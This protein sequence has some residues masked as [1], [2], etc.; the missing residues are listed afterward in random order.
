LA[1]KIIFTAGVRF[2]PR[3]IDT[4]LIRKAISTAISDMKV[5]LA[6]KQVTVQRSAIN[7]ISQQL[8]QKI[9]VH[10][11]A[12]NFTFNGGAVAAR[13]GKIIRDAGKELKLKV[14]F[15]KAHLIA[16]VKQTLESMGVTVPAKV[17]LQDPTKSVQRQ[18]A[19]PGKQL[20]ADQEVQNMANLVRVQ[21]D[22]QSSMPP[23]LRAQ[24]Q[25]A[26]LLKNSGVNA[27]WFG[28]KIAQVTAR[29]AAYAVAIRGIFA[30]QQAF[31]NS[32]D[33]IIKFDNVISDLQKVL[34]T[35]PEVLKNTADSMFQVAEATGRSFEDVATAMNTFIRQDLGVTKALEMTQAALMATNISELTAA[36][37]TKFLT[38]VTRVYGQ[39]AG[40]TTRIL[41]VLSV[42]ADNAATTAAGL[43]QA[44]IRSGAAAKAVGVT[45]GEL[46]AVTAAVIETTQSS[47]EKVGTALKTIF[48]RL[49][50]TNDKIRA[51]AN[52]WGANIQATDGV[53]TTLEK[54]SG[55]YG[56]L[57]MFQR[58]QL[59]YLVAGRRRFTEFSA[60]L[61]GFGKTN[62]LLAKQENAA[63]TAAAK[64]EVELSKLS[65]RVQQIRNIWNEFIQELAGTKGGAEGVGLLRG[66]LEDV[67]SITKE[68]SSGLKGI[69]V[70]IKEMG[71]S[72]LQVSTVF[73]AIAKTAFFTIGL[74][75]IR[76][77][78]A[79][80]RQFLQIGQ[81]IQGLLIGVS[82]KEKEILGMILQQ[83]QAAEG[84]AT[85]DQRRLAIKE[86]MA[87]AESR[88][89]TASMRT[90]LAEKRA[91]AERGKV[92][93]AARGAAKSGAGKIA[94]FGAFFL[95]TQLLADGMKNFAEEIG[96]IAAKTGAVSQEFAAGVSRLGGKAVEL[97]AIVTAVTGNLKSGLIA[98]I[99][100]AGIQLALFA[101]ELES[102]KWTVLE[103]ISSQSSMSLSVLDVVRQNN[104]L[105]QA[106][107][108]LTGNVG[109]LRDVFAAV[110]LVRAVLEA[111]TIAS[112]QFNDRLS[113]LAIATEQ[114]TSQLTA[115]SRAFDLQRALRQATQNIQKQV[116]QIQVGL[117]AGDFGSEFAP[118]IDAISEYEARLQNIDSVHNGVYNKIEATKRALEAWS[119][120]QDPA[121]GDS[122]RILDSYQLLSTEVS[123]LI[124]SQREAMMIAEQEVDANDAIISMREEEIS[125]IKKSIDITRKNL[126]AIQNI[127]SATSERKALQNDLNILENASA[128][129]NKQIVELNSKNEILLGRINDANEEISNVMKQE[130]ESVR[131][132]VVAYKSQ[133]ASVD[134]SL[135]KEI[136]RLAKTELETVELQK[137]V[138]IYENLR[139]KGSDF[140]NSVT[141][142]LSAAVA[143]LNNEIDK[144]TQQY[145]TNI[146]K[147]QQ[148][149]DAAAAAGD[150]QQANTLEDKR[151]ALEAVQKELIKALKDKGIVELQAKFQK[152]QDEEV[153]AQSKALADYRISQIQAVIDVETSANN[154][155]IALIKQLAGTD[156]FARA[157]RSQLHQ[158]P[159]A[160]ITE[161]GKAGALIV[162]EQQR[163]SSN[164]VNAIQQ[165]YKSLES[166]GI[167]SSEKLQS[168]L[169]ARDRLISLAEEE[170]TTKREVILK[171]AE[172]S[173]EKVKSAEQRLID[174]RE[175]IPQLN[176]AV[177]QAEQQLA[178]S[179]MAHTEAV[180]NFF[181]ASQEA[182][183]A[184]VQYNVGLEKARA[185]IIINNAGVGDFSEKLGALGSVWNTAV[186]RVRA[187]EEQILQIRADI[188]QQALSIY[189]QQL[190]AVKGLSIQAATAGAEDIAKLRATIGAGKAVVGGANVLQIPEELRTGL[191]SIAQV[192]PGLEDA[193]MRQGAELL[194]LDPSV[195]NKIENQ[196]LELAQTTAEA[197]KAQVNEAV[198]QVSVAMTQ[199][200]RADQQIEEAK[201][202]LTV[203]EEIRDRAVSQA[204]VAERGFGVAQATHQSIIRD[205]AQQLNRLNTLTGVNRQILG[206][207]NNMNNNISSALGDLANA[208]SKSAA[209]AAS[210]RAGEVPNVAAGSL[211]STEM[212]ALIRAARREKSAMPAGSRLMLANTSEIV[213]NRHQ[214]QKMNLVPMPKQ[215]AANGNAGT[216]AGAIGV[217]A[218]ALLSA[219]NS[220]NNRLSSPGGIAEQNFNINIDSNKKIQV[221]GIDT[222]NKAMQ[223]AFTEKMSGVT[224]KQEFQ[225]V[226]DTVVGMAAKLK[227][228][229]I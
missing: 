225:A 222:L 67:L 213:L 53:I 155:R 26:Q 34:Q 89:Y 6:I 136:E 170:I 133:A 105:S 189:Q 168:S 76:G 44:F 180:S 147:I 39:E 167:G 141:G 66:T 21:K 12:T 82:G 140:A 71:G 148:L 218:N 220:L 152:S 24:G 217:A 219:V 100:S 31:N 177:M 166:V 129:F 151:K 88:N 96:M 68:L 214:A 40:D 19:A 81:V 63:G 42:T 188:A 23:L 70:G 226:R 83:A 92:S 49:V 43:A 186:G 86:Q 120:L 143:G 97:G 181:K 87:R 229:G 35:T 178:Q 169:Q 33:A 46:Q 161:F 16:Q 128:S 145:Q 52:A 216:D 198:K 30:V 4:K 179:R 221:T 124:A 192:I 108:N 3:D 126:A 173:V 22:L 72:V 135:A 138:S 146:K 203:A 25:Y 94:Q 62:E 195:F 106:V 228:V 122:E 125:Q 113:S 114:V 172:G 119:K 95:A 45:Y 38:T 91:Q 175:K 54:L 11:T 47:S 101:N 99:I 65:T 190:G 194:G 191:S 14:G 110:G 84:L 156:V 48:S 176:T 15:D 55:I 224:N 18:M 123:S 201:N 115:A 227:E 187:S 2:D 73:K 58:G 78:I 196:M 162:N 98:G 104:A 57:D 157:F 102:H 51:Q 199:V 132:L 207:I 131:D 182:A 200:A 139:S 107:R 27:E 109:E 142:Q 149:I 209:A 210:L 61:Q 164:A 8:S 93:G 7:S 212:S 211:S 153:K 134:L 144:V 154:K 160:L 41:D 90:L 208:A 223:Q 121:A 184:Q 79:G 118:V 158:I 206:A 205:G 75:V 56:E 204:A 130:V 77:V 159:D 174:A 64:Q 5:N 32:L 165:Q 202:Q 215:Y 60:I 29:F 112:S 197:G 69:V 28:G 183:N 37:A 185:N 137:Q 9:K 103:A 111:T 13:L 163:M 10:L 150:T 17:K 127:K 85:I 1:K 20:V 193:L 117:D 171:R 50:T 74:T 36:E 59:A 116:A 80:L